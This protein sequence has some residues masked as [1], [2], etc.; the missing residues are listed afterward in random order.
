MNLII[1]S[2]V[3]LAYG[4]SVAM[5]GNYSEWVEKIEKLGGL[6][7]LFTEEE[8]GKLEKKFGKIVG[9][10]RKSPVSDFVNAGG[11]RQF[12]L[13][14]SVW[15]LE[16]EF[17]KIRCG[18]DSEIIPVAGWVGGKFTPVDPPE[19]END[20]YELYVDLEVGQEEMT[21]W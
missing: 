20:P 8:W 21:C 5:T 14:V 1:V 7:F 15:K 12:G 3:G 10:S 4:K 13:D 11:C 9:V 17:E 6:R 19:E 18:Y 2:C 16:N